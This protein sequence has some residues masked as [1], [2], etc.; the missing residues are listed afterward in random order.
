M[1]FMG[2][3]LPARLVDI[4]LRL[5][6]NIRSRHQISSPLA[7]QGI[8]PPPRTVWFPS[9]HR[10]ASSSASSSSSYSPISCTPGMRPSSSIRSPIRLCSRTTSTSANCPPICATI[11][12]SRRASTLCWPKV[13]G[14]VRASSVFI[15]ARQ[16]ESIG[17]RSTKWWR[18]RVS[19]R[20]GSM[21]MCRRIFTFK[22]SLE[23]L[24]YK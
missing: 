6:L 10:P 12:C 13:A 14:W 17:R 23:C 24:L 15:S 19:F 8:L 1:I 2:H 3:I 5:V 9:D 22:V 20:D 16:T 18:M 11:G 4:Y 7:T 21:Q